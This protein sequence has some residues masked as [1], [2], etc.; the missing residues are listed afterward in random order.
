MLI[1]LWRNTGF[2]IA[3]RW[4]TFWIRSSKHIYFAKAPWN[5]PLFSER[6]VYKPRS[7][8]GWRFF[9]RDVPALNDIERTG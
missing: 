8:F 3:P 5:E 4:G 1:R 2:C 6:Y 9:R 7:Y